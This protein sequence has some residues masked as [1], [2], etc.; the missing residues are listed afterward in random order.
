MLLPQP[1]SS[2]NCAQCSGFSDSLTRAGHPVRFFHFRMLSSHPGFEASCLCELLLSEPG[3]RTR[4]FVLIPNPCQMTSIALPPPRRFPHPAT[5]HGA[6]P[7][8]N[9]PFSSCTPSSQSFRASTS[10]SITATSR[11]GRTSVRYQQDTSPPSLCN[12]L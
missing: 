8:A 1:L 7:H 9:V 6:Q 10:Y 4:L 11:G 12:C 2:R 5:Q 3:G